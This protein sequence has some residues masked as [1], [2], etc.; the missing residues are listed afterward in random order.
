MRRR[1]SVF[2]RNLTGE[3][4]GSSRKCCSR[5]T[6]HLCAGTRRSRWNIATAALSMYAG[7]KNGRTGSSKG[8]RLVER[9]ILQ[10][11][12]ASLNSG[13]TFDFL[14]EFFHEYECPDVHD[15]VYKL[16]GPLLSDEDS[17]G[18][19]LEVNY[20]KT[21]A[22]LFDD[23]MI[24]VKE[25]PRLRSP[26]A[27]ERFSKTSQKALAFPP[28]K[29]PFSECRA[30]L[31]KPSPIIFARA[32]RRLRLEC[33][34]HKSTREPSLRLFQEASNVIISAAYTNP[35]AVHAT[36]CSMAARISLSANTIP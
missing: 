32:W 20:A 12:K 5:N 7:R 19:I 22:Q 31:A 16:L 34:N 29:C 15:K 24:A 1:A 4:R 23:V 2:S 10:G 6:R 8:A 14:I 9:R 13:Y 18:N 33:I 26:R 28:G 21:P 35:S 27:L 30:L 17:R 11:K 36:L 25:S 3:G